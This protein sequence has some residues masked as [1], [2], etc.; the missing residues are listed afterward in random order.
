MD[1][2]KASV[3]EVHL[4]IPK[5]AVTQTVIDELVAIGLKKAK[6]FL[7]VEDVRDEKMSCNAQTPP[8][9]HDIKDPGMMFTTK[10]KAVEEAIGLVKAGMRVLRTLKV[11]GNFEIEGQIGEQ[12]VS[13]R[14]I[15]LD[16]EMPEYKIIQDAPAYEN[17][18][19][20]RGTLSEI[21][22]N[23]EIVAFIQRE[24]GFSPHQIVDFAR[25]EV[26]G[27]HDVIS[28]VATIYQPDAKSVFAFSERLDM[29][30]SIQ[31]YAYAIGE[32]VMM[33]GEDK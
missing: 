1:M 2:T 25:V 6:W 16:R 19:V 12:F 30:G 26:A 9:G 31:P 3:V 14:D 15:D 24:F 21:P 10:V 33:V 23:R 13:Y 17:H 18:I 22:T 27:P 20:W 29:D 4:A 32:R 11:Y 5:R 28:R 8:T 7:S